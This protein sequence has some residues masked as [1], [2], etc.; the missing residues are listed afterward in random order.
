MSPGEMMGWVV[1]VGFVLTMIVTILALVGILNVRE[2]YLK[3]LFAVL[4]VEMV[5]AGFFLFYQ[6]F[7]RELDAGFDPEPSSEV[8]LFD[9]LG[10]PFE[11]VLLTG[12]DTVKAFPG[13]DRDAL[14]DVVR[15]IDVDGDNLVI[16][17]REGVLLGR[18]PEAAD[19]IGTAFFTPEQLLALGLH[20]AECAVREEGACVSRRS[21]PQA[22]DY[23][24]KAI[25]AGA[26]T[27]VQES[28][29]TQLVFL[30]G[31]INQ[32]SDFRQLA[33]A[34]TRTRMPPRRYHE[35]GEIYLA[36]SRSLGVEGDS[37]RRLEAR[38]AALKYY[39][40]YLTELD[41]TAASDTTGVAMGARARVRE[42]WGPLADHLPQVGDN[43]A[44][45]FERGARNAADPTGMSRTLMR[46]YSDGI[47]P[48][49]TCDNQ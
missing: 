1:V 24:L 39:L 15:S 7:G 21:A 23:L 8:Y 20:Y 11:S 6:S 36:S 25:A 9:R 18:V 17:S 30:L 5:G 40:A 43:E 32:C 13:I 35:L 12:E 29:A 22:V 46:Q 4:V 19:A 14:R 41:P 34:I 48:N 26:E 27:S 16:R 2:T 28:A 37:D 38:K 31:Y 42:L 10:E 3:R 47:V 44:P 33:D 49:F 45:A